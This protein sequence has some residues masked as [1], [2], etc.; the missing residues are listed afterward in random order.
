VRSGLPPT[1]SHY[2]GRFKPRRMTRPDLACSA[3]DI[4]QKKEARPSGRAFIRE[5]AVFFGF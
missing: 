3:R 1:A 4:A 2:F 5:T